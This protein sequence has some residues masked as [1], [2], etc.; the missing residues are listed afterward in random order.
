MAVFAA[1]SVVCL[2]Q[3]LFDC[4]CAVRWSLLQTTLFEGFI[5]VNI[6]HG[7]SADAPVLSQ[8]PRTDAK[9]LDSLPLV[10]HTFSTLRDTLDVLSRE[11]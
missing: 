2:Y 9:E 1:G 5:R 10:S 6:S 11:F 8:P 7:R 4:D 3:S